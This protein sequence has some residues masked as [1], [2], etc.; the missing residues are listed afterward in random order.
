[1]H[2]KYADVRPSGEVLA[3][4]AGLTPGMFELPS[5]IGVV[6]GRSE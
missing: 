3:F 5:G 6:H 2:S 4:M 1:M